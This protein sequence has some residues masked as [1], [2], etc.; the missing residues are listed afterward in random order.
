MGN[1]SHVVVWLVDDAESVR[2]SLTAVLETSNITVRDYPTARAFLEDYQASSA[3]CLIVDH[4]MPDMTGIQLLQHLRSAGTTL[5]SILISGH[6]DN[7]LREKALAAGAV[8]MFTKPVDG[9]ELITFIERL[10]ANKT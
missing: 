6:G 9:N 10:I 7:A 8:A 1:K 3:S 5:P 2:H 4:H